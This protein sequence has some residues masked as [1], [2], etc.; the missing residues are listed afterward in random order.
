[1]RA[2]VGVVVGGRGRGGRDKR[3]DD[4]SGEKLLVG[5]GEA[6]DVGEGVK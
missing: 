4:Q 1:M 3:G 2:A 5:L 6:E